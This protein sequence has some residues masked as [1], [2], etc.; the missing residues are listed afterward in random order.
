MYFWLFFETG[1]YVVEV[2]IE[3]EADS[4]LLVH[5]LPHPYFL[6]CSKVFVFFIFPFYWKDII[7]SLNIYWL[8]FALSLLFSSFSI[9]YIILFN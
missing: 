4:E 8:Q 9:L 6:K 5:F 3:A 7:F 1:S 2:D